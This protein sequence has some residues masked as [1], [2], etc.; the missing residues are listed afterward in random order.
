MGIR[1]FIGVRDESGEVNIGTE[2]GVIKARAFKRRS[3]G[4]QRWSWK[5]LKDHRG[6]LFLGGK[7]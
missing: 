2:H 4:E 6:S 1:F 7:E 3:E 5:S